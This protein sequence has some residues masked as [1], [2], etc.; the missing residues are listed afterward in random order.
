MA[1]KLWLA[2]VWNNVGV[3][4]IASPTEMV[5]QLL[6]RTGKRT[7]RSERVRGSCATGGGAAAGV[8]STVGKMVVVVQLL[9]SPRGWLSWG[10]MWGRRGCQALLTS[11]CSTAAMAGV[12]AYVARM[13]R[14]APVE[15]SVTNS[16]WGVPPYTWWGEI[17]WLWGRRERRE[18]V[19]SVPSSRLLVAV[20]LSSSC[21]SFGVIQ[22]VSPRLLSNSFFTNHHVIPVYKLA[23]ILSH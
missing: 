19:A 1:P 17:P 5:A 9:V 21:P 20:F 18:V 15:W 6:R 23:Y 16:P 7:W 3:S 22:I 8:A 10:R 2:S 12:E 14:G 13:D 11:C 4:H